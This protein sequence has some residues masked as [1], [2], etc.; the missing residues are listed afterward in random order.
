MMRPGRTTRSFCALFIFLVGCVSTRPL[1]EATRT[2][3]RSVVLEDSAATSASVSVG[4]VN[5]DGHEDMVLVKGRHWPLENLVLL[6]N[7]NGTFRR[8]Y[9]L[10][11]APDRSY[12]GVLVDVDGDGDLDVVVSNDTPDAKIVYLNNGG[13]RFVPGGTFGRAEWPTRHISVVDLNNDGFMDVVLANRYGNQSGPSY[14]CF[15]VRGGHFADECVP[16]AQGSATTI[17]PADVNGDGAQDLVVPHRDAGQS[18]VYLNDRTGR[19]VDRR[20]F[21]PPD[22]S[23]RSAEPIDL[24]ADGVIDL[25]A[26][27]DQTGSAIFWGRADGT[28]STGETLGINSATP[29]AVAV[30]DLDRNDRPD[31]I[32][33]Y[34]NSRPAVYFNDRPRSFHAVPF[35]DNEGTAYG[36]AVAD[37]DE[38]GFWDI[39]MA[40]S[41]AR[42]M[43]YFGGPAN[44]GR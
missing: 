1:E 25:V 4:D 11:G 43:L 7:G 17:K 41:D 15:G 8:A 31:V 3:D 40:R 19:F 36:F 34:V 37:F 42:N 29:Y 12:S 38:D 20:P 39:A 10:A 33:G 22:A 5:A 27:D 23:I 35:G 18:F 32:I 2:F 16:F 44:S 21:G 26:I 14:I 24:D 6:G 13:G 28:Y 30:A 9:P